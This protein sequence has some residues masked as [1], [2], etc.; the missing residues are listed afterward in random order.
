MKTA[1]D[2]YKELIKLRVS[3]AMR[4]LGFIGSGGTYVFP[5]EHMWALVGLQGSVYSDPGE[6]SFTVNV[7]VS[8][9]RNFA[10]FVGSDRRRPSAN[11]E[12][13][14]VREW[15]V[16]LGNLMKA[17]TDAQNLDQWWS[18]TPESDLTVVAGEVLDA[19]TT[20]ALPEVKRRLSGEVALDPPRMPLDREPAD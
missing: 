4:R 17:E 19:V 2:A 16:R 20:Y 12:Y 3:P 9:K 1:Q 15:H 7:K 11:G 14:Q 5:H 18:V 13:P 8:D 10:S 6:V